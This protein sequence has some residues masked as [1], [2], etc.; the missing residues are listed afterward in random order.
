M[1]QVKTLRKFAY[2]PLR[3]PGGKSSLF[4]FFC[5]IFDKNNWTDFTYIEPY[6][7]GAGSA[8]AF[9]TSGNNEAS[10]MFPLREVLMAINLRT[11]QH[12][13]INTRR[14]QSFDMAFPER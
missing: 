12:L 1:V 3:Y 10:G 4:G 11:A 9:M 6:A 5:N 7:G 13:G 14:S 2:S 8:L